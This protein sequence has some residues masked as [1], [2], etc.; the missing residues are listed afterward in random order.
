MKKIDLLK[1]LYKHKTEM[2]Y[3]MDKRTIFEI[4][5]IIY[6]NGTE[7]EFITDEFFLNFR[8]YKIADIAEVTKNLTKKSI[9]R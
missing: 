2:F 8:E 1:K 3:D 6:D 9:T 7:K 5:T 4:T